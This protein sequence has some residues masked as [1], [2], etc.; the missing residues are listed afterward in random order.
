[1]VACNEKVE[2]TLYKFLSSVELG[3]HTEFTAILLD[4]TVLTDPNSGLA[5]KAFLHEMETSSRGL[6]YALHMQ[7][8][9]LAGTGYPHDGRADN[10]LCFI[11]LLF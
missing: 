4:C 9:A 1:M 6:C 10:A 2:Y 11:C 3:D 5:L 8:T 7:H